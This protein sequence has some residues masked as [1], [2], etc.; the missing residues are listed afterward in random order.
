MFGSCWGRFSGR[1]LGHAWDMCGRFVGPCRELLDSFGEF[2]E[3]DKAYK[4]PIEN[5]YTL[6]NE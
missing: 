2:L 3:V 5:T 4:R 6:L 1:L